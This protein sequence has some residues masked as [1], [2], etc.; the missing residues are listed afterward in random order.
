MLET[1]WGIGPRRKVYDGGGAWAD[2]SHIVWQVITIG[3]IIKVLATVTVINR[4]NAVAASIHHGTVWSKVMG[5][6]IL[7][8]G[9]VQQGIVYGVGGEVVE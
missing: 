6:D 4:P 8:V 7:C 5:Y 9:E 3:P 2:K 1:V